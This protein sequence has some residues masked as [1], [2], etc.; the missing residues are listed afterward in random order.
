[1]RKL[2]LIISGV[3]IFGPI[4][5]KAA[6]SGAGL[7]PTTV[8]VGYILAIGFLKIEKALATK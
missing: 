7:V 1:M 3:I 2:A 6:A 8:T 5:E 4:E